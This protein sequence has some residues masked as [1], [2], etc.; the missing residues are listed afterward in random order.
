MPA[1]NSAR[2]LG[3]AIESVLRQTYKN[4]EIIVVDDGSTDNT[5]AVLD[6]YRTSI[7]VLARPNGGPSAARNHGLS[8]ASGEYVYFLDADDLVYPDGL[9]SL[10]S[11]LETHPETDLVAGEWDTF[12]VTSNELSSRSGVT[13]TRNTSQVD[14]CRNMLIETLFPIHAALTRIGPVRACGGWDESLWCAED[15][16]L[17]LR[18]ARQGSHFHFLSV[19]VAR[20]RRHPNNSTL[21]FPRME[22][23]MLRFL[24]KWFGPS[25]A[26][27]ADKALLKPYAYGL[28][29]L[30]LAKQCREA[31]MTDEILQCAEAARKWFTEAKPDETLVLRVLWDSYEMPWEQAIHSVLWPKSKT[32]VAELCWVHGRQALRQHEPRN[33]LLW[34]MTLARNRPGHFATKLRRLLSR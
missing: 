5:M 12:D 30:F 20:Y 13:A 21:N 25:A 32:S 18:L 6:P 27:D 4:Y 23:H 10:V 17:W 26:N 14:L 8:M 7:K 11:H 24:E 16:D 28:A 33:A 2:F 29:W 15:R 22:Q 19:P 34:F 9:S 1:Y 3:E 31:Q